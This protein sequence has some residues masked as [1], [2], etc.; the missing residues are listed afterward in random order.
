MQKEV[1]GQ[2]SLQV[3]GCRPKRKPQKKSYNYD[4]DETGTQK[5]RQSSATKHIQQS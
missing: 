1:N 2:L 5:V 3:D 4:S